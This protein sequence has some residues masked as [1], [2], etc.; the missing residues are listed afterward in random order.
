V[1]DAADGEEA[2]L[3]SRDLDHIETLGRV[4]EVTIGAGLAKPAGSA[5]AVFGNNQVH[6]LLKGLLNFEEEK[7]RLKKEIDKMDKEIETAERKLS[8]RG[9]LDKAPA[10]VVDEVREKREALAT[11]REKLSKNLTFF[12]ESDV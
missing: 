12:E 1:I 4:E 7:R 9:F 11:K 5:S 6:V 8:N 10:E 2:S 3:L